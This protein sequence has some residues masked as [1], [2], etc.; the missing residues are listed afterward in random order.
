MLRAHLAENICKQVL[1][2]LQSTFTFRDPPVEGEVIPRAYELKNACIRV[3]NY[4]MLD[5][6]L[7]RPQD[8][9]RWRHNGVS[10]RQCSVSSGQEVEK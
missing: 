10:S 9:T 6:L 3:G 1:F 5:Y 2:Y 4:K 7:M 8:Q